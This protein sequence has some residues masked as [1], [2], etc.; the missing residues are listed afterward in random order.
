[1]RGSLYVDRTGVFGD[2]LIAVTTVG[3][4]WR[5]ESTGSPTILAQISGQLEGMITVPNDVAKYGPLAG[6]IIAGQESTGSLFTIDPAGNVVEHANIGVAI[7][8]I[9][10]I[11]PN[12]NFFGMQFGQDAIFW[13]DASDFTA[14]VGEILL[15]SEFGGAS[16]G[17]YR[18]FWDG[19]NLQTEEFTLAAGSDP[20]GQWEHV[21]F[22]PATIGV[23][24]PGM[25]LLLGTGL[26]GLAGYKRRREIR[27]VA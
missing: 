4:V 12:E 24:E 20:R 11:V 27:Q 3:G 17:L 7:E 23:P 16:T 26:L 10:L 6:K 18:L 14:F 25:V 15:T 2:D 19:M 13:A 9:D 8:D 5:G 21:T 1:M 22:A